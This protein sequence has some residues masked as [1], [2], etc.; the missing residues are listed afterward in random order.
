MQEQ[1]SLTKR[2][3]IEINQ[4]LQTALHEMK[5]ERDEFARSWKLASRRVEQL[6]RRYGQVQQH[7]EKL[8]SYVKS[9]RNWAAAAT[10]ARRSET[11][12]AQTASTGMTPPK[13][14]SGR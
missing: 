13:S 5:A 1:R 8:S 2:E 11:A 14:G 12:T 9:L 10:A 6:T 7:Y 3:L 4:Q